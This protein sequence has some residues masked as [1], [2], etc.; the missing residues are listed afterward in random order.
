MSLNSKV[1]YSS[2]QSKI[3][4]FAPITSPRVS[5][6]PIFSSILFAPSSYANVVISRQSLSLIL[7]YS[8]C[9]IAQCVSDGDYAGYRSSLVNLAHHSIFTCC[10]SILLNSVYLRSLLSP[11]TFAWQTIFAFNRWRAT[12]SIVEPKSLI[13]RAC[14]VCNI[15]WV[16]PWVCVF[17]IPTPT[18]FVSRTWN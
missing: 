12:H 16:D 18:T 2:Y 7:E 8:T 10:K 15:V 9:V 11:T 1:V 13:G 6:N 5:N 4:S 14:F 17:G 3:S